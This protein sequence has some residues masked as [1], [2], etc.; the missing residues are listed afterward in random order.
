MAALATGT[1]DPTTQRTTG[2]ALFA[3]V[4]RPA[5]P[6]DTAAD[7]VWLLDHLGN[8]MPGWPASLPAAVTTPPVMVGAYPS[9]LVLVGCS[10]GYVRELALDGTT[11]ASL[12]PLPAPISGRLA[13]LALG[14]PPANLYVAAGDTLGNVA[15]LA[16]P[17]I[18]VTVPCPGP[19]MHAVGG[20]GFAPDFLWIDF[21]GTGPQ[22]DSPG[23]S[24]VARDGDRLFAFD[25]TGTP[26]PGW[27][28]PFPDTLVA[29]LGAGDPD[30]DGYPEVLVQTRHSGVAFVNTSGGPSPGWPRRTSDEDLVGGCPALAADVDG[31]HRSEVV[32]LNPAG[33]IAAVRADGRVPAGWPLAAGAGARGAPVIADLDGDGFLEVVAGDNVSS[34]W[35]YGLPA[36]TGGDTPIATSWTMLGGDPGRT[37]AL[38]LARTPVALAPSAGPLV[39]ASLKAYPNPAR[40]K[41]VTFG[42]TLTEPARVEFHVLDTSGHQVASFARDG[43]QADNLVVW[44]PGSLPAGL[45]LVQV[46]IQGA[47]DRHDE[48]L[49][50]GLLR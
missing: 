48:T 46:R 29:G 5:F 1:T 9:A 6:G 44:D 39:R 40:R 22:A 45:Y 25:F 8:A 43:R 27:G 3:V 17:V 16:P 15:M 19:W 18:C 20:P 34:M 24:L 10:D 36:S 12:G 28:R 13:A 31:D 35:A 42:F 41:P 38:P 2:P 37:S 23:Y 30:G 4:T 26:L 33:V 50:V 14:P 7:K 21:G 47:R 49:Q 32:A 11:V